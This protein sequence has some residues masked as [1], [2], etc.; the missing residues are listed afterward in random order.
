M[1]TESGIGLDQ[2]KLVGDVVR[3]VCRVIKEEF[4]DNAAE[5]I[6]SVLIV[7]L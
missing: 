7:E 2:V 1:K 5:V 3:E 6:R 4:P